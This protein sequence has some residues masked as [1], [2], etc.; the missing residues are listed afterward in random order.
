[1]TGCT[2]VG[3]THVYRL[4][5]PLVVSTLNYGY[6]GDLTNLISGTTIISDTD[7]EFF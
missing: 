4:S 3:D 1:M 5:N 7:V 2:A 6:V